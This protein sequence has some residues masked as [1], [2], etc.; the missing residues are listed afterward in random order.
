MMSSPEKPRQSADHEERQRRIVVDQKAVRRRVERCPSPS[1]PAQNRRSSPRWDRAERARPS[2]EAA[3]KSPSRQPPQKQWQE[4]AGSHRACAAFI[5]P[6]TACRAR[7]RRG[8]RSC[9]HAQSQHWRNLRA[10]PVPVNHDRLVEVAL[11]ENQIGKHVTDVLVRSI[12]LPRGRSARRC[13]AASP[14]ARLRR[15][16]AIHRRK[17]MHHMLALGREQ[18]RRERT[19]IDDREFRHVPIGLIGGPAERIAVEDGQQAARRGT[20]LLS[21][22]RNSRIARIDARQ[23]VRQDRCLC[24]KQLPSAQA[25]RRQPSGGAR[26]RYSSD[27]NSRSRR[28]RPASRRCTPQPPSAHS[29]ATDCADSEQRRAPTHMCGAIAAAASKIRRAN[30][31]RRTPVRT[32]RRHDRSETGWRPRTGPA[33][34]SKRL[35]SNAQVPSLWAS[36]TER[37]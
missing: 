28:T 29:G 13:P 26:V 2:T 34:V 3:C 33:I 1:P 4:P 23:S 5:A 32:I 11:E 22:A 10:R 31:R 37:K 16:N 24:S 7:C 30:R 6:G 27:A 19:A 35:N 21:A 17:Y 20:I 14:V 18:Q 8:R 36:G 25:A 9:R 12:G 15:H